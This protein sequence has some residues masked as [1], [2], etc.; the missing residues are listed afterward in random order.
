MTFI[1]ISRNRDRVD[2]VNTTSNI[3]LQGL[4]G[5]GSVVIGDGDTDVVGTDGSEDVAGIGGASYWGCTITEVPSDSM[6]IVNT[7]IALHRR[8]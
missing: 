7:W 1:N 2:R 3:N 8:W 5:A 4:A 6:S